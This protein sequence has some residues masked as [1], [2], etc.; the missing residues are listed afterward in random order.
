MSSWDS[1]S[2]LA[3]QEVQPKLPPEKTVKEVLEKP[4]YWIRETYLPAYRRGRVYLD[5]LAGA[6]AAAMG[7]SPYEWADK[8]APEVGRAVAARVKEALWL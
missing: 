1:W 5:V 2:L 6:V 8:L 7:R 3:V 4:P